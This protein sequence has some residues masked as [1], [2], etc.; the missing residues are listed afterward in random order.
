MYHSL[1]LRDTFIAHRL[2]TKG[3]SICSI[4]LTQWSRKRNASIVEID[5]MVDA[6][7]QSI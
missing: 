6:K 5:E 4:F 1:W 7:K 3:S 2:S